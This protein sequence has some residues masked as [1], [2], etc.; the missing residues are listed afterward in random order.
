MRILLTNDDGILAPGLAALYAAVCDMGEVQVVAPETS[1]SAAGH[2]LTVHGSVVVQ[3]VPLPFGARGISVQGR[4]ADCVKLA[5]RQ[6]LAEPP[7]L[8]L[9]GINAG[10]NIGINVL[11]SGTVAAAMEAA[12]LG[13]PAVAFSLA[14][15]TEPDF[16]R[17]ARH[18]RAVLEELLAADLARPGGMLNVNIPRLDDGEPKGIRVARQGSGRL[19]EQYMRVEEVDNCEAYRLT[20]TYGFEDP[21]ADSDIA[22]LEAGYITITPLQ[23]DLTD[24]AG[25]DVLRQVS[26]KPKRH[27]A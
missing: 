5:Y 17:A 12:I 19:I 23:A 18:C 14:V 21:P 11:Y 15:G 4:P 13:M 16:P 22:A 27:K 2:A 26:W 8:V 7:D 3:T 24:P 20:D 6:L 10:A 9:S 1:Q 25:L